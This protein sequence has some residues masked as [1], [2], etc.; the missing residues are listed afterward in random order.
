MPSLKGSYFAAAGAACTAGR[1]PASKTS[2]NMNARSPGSF[3]NFFIFFTLV[4]C[5]IP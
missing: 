1:S 5:F 2:T 3:E 4:T